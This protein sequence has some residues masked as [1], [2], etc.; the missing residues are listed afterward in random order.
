MIARTCTR[1]S[2]AL[3]LA[4][5]AMTSGMTLAADGATKDE[6]VALVKKAAA[7]IK[8][9]A[10]KAYAE[11]DDRSGQFV[12]RD[13]YI[14]VYGLDGTVLAHGADKTRIGTNQLGDKDPDGKAFVQE[15]VELAK[16]QPSFWQSYKFKNPVTGTV[17]PKQMYCERLDQ[18]VVCGGVYLPPPE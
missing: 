9:E 11:I 4:A 10:D 15:R 8:A 3:A 6:A 7:F 12:D 14:V 1:V 13:L 16:E 2:G 17:E 18:S 5:I